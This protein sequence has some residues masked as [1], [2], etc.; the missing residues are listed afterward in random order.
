MAFKTPRR[1]WLKWLITGLSL[2]LITS[3][4][5]TLWELLRASQHP[6]EAYLV[7]GGSIRREMYMADLSQAGSTIPVLISSGSQ[8]PCIRLLYEQRSAPLDQVWLEKCA[9]STFGNFFFSLP[10]LKRWQVHKV[11][12]V[13]SGS[14]TQRAVWMGRIMLGA[15]RLWVEPEIV[16]EQGIP[17]N[18]ENRLKTALDL[19]R[20]VLWAM[21][22]Q[23]YS[24]A[25]QEVIPLSEVNLNQWQQQGFHCEHQAGIESGQE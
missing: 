12:L 10:I 17:G 7:L 9:H 2:A 15:H 8:D 5:F 19:T 24:P 11:K 14:H 23:V 22:S 16:S 3:G 18:Q 21:V 1:P 25:C 6:V 4:G 13:T 20:S